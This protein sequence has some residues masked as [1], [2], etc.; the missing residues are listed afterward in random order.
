MYA[1][2]QA[3]ICDANPFEIGH[4]VVGKTRGVWTLLVDR[5]EHVLCVMDTEGLG[6][7]LKAGGVSGCC[8]QPSS[9]A[10]IDLRVSV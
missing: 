3:G 2:Q 9:S 4:T 7:A 1:S 6:D 8:L 5:G 10:L